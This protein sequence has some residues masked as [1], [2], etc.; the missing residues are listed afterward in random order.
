MASVAPVASG[1]GVGS[2]SASGGASCAG[3]SGIASA[4]L[5]D[6]ARWRRSI[7]EVPTIARRTVANHLGG[8][9]VGTQMRGIALFPLLVP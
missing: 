3:G 5:R 9:A 7:Y 8:F 6:P 4:G 1:F 2:E